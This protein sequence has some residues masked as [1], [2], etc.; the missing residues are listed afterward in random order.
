MSPEVHQQE[1]C[2][3]FLKSALITRKNVDSS[4][5]SSDIVGELC[6][7]G[8]TLLFCYVEAIMVG[9]VTDIFVVSHF[10][11]KP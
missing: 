7:S 11:W 9:I 2:E 5:L 4:I 6:D 8:L 10:D 3:S 1:G